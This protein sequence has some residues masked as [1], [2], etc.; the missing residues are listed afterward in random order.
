MKIE[1]IWLL[2]ITLYLLYG[3]LTKHFR[4]EFA[5]WNI[6]LWTKFKKG[7]SRGIFKIGFGDW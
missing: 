4:I 2:L 3:C 7:G 1:T 5:K 6:Q